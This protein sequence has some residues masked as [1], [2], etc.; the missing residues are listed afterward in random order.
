[1]PKD[2]EVW[3]RAPT[4]KRSRTLQDWSSQRWGSALRGPDSNRLRQRGFVKVA[5]F[6]YDNSVT[7]GES[8]IFR[9]PEELL[10]MDAQTRQ[11]LVRAKTNYGAKDHTCFYRLQL[12]GDEGGNRDMSMVE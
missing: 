6:Q 2:I 8:Q 1:M 4:D 9:L 12:W 7:K 5:E 10:N 3:I 11:V